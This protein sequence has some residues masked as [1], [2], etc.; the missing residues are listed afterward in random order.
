MSTTEVA[1]HS[2][3]KGDAVAAL[4][5]TVLGAVPAADRVAF[6]HKFE[7]DPPARPLWPWVFS[8]AESGG[9]G[10]AW[11]WG[12]R[13]ELVRRAKIRKS[14]AQL[15]PPPALQAWSHDLSLGRTRT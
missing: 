14:T 9:G 2:V 3:T 4:Q 5:R 7:I 11:V 8:P 13:S 1:V 15:K 6:F 10:A 12:Q